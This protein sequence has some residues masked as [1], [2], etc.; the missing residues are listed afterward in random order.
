MALG[1]PRKIYTLEHGWLSPSTVLELK[2]L[3]RRDI[4]EPSIDTE[5]SYRHRVS[6][7]RR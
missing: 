7:M 3:W 1:V 5:S 4:L 2:T 6:P